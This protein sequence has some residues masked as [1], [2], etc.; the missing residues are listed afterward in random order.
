MWTSW[1]VTIHSTQ[2]QRG[3]LKNKVKETMNLGRRERCA[4]SFPIPGSGAALSCAR[5]RW[6]LFLEISD[7]EQVVFLLAGNCPR[8]EL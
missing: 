8:E 6:P 2:I 1:P 5:W 7:Y 3:K 4:F